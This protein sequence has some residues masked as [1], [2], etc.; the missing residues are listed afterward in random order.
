MGILISRPDNSNQ[1]AQNDSD[2]NR[3]KCNFQGIL[4]TVRN[5]FPTVV[6]DKVKIKVSD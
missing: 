4:E 2:E 1:K 3:K 6:F 5:L